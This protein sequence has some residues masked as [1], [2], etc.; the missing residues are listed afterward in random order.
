MARPVL[1]PFRMEREPKVLVL[2][3]DFEEMLDLAG[4]RTTREQEDRV[5]VALI[6]LEHRGLIAEIRGRQPWAQIIVIAG[7]GSI[8]AAK[9]ALRAG[10]SDFLEKPL[11]PMAVF[12]AVLDALERREWTLYREPQ[13]HPCWID[14]EGRV[15]L[16]RPPADPLYLELPVEGGEIEENGALFKM[17]DRQRRIHAFPSPI[18]GRVIRVNE[19]LIENPAGLQGNPWIVHL[20]RKGD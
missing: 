5:D 17:I 19:A 13:G 15:G 6:D 11:D 18:A 3:T 16:S 4:L 9:T 1:F 12:R 2:N 14:A 10:A 8:E 20:E 7:P